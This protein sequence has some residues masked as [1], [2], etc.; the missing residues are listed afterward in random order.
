METRISATLRLWGASRQGQGRSKT[1]RGL[2]AERGR[3]VLIL[4]PGAFASGCHRR[5]LTADN[6]YLK[7]SLAAVPGSLHFI[8]MDWRHMFEMMSAGRGAYSELKNLCVWAKD[9]AGRAAFTAASTN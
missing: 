3:R 6:P 9:S 8:F 5:R 4:W 2:A 7:V 1:L